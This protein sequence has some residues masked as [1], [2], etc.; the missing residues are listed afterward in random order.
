MCGIV[1]IRR[2]DGRPIDESQL[3]EMTRLLT[4]R[5]PDSEGYGI[6]G[7]V[8]FG[9]RRLAIIDVEGSPQPMTSGSRPVHVTYN[10]EIFNYKDLR[11]QLLKRKT[12][13]KTHGDTETLVELG[14]APEKGASFL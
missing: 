10:G 4:H 3:R 6:Y 7:S 8:G 1:G 11:D 2:F 9:H 14:S 12:P 5:G 13:L